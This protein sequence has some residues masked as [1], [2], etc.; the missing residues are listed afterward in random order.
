MASMREKRWGAAASVV[1][2]TWLVTGG[3]YGGPFSLSSTE[4][5]QGG[6]W[7]AGPGLPVGM[8]SHC[9][10]TVGQGVVVTGRQLVRTYCQLLAG[11]HQASPSTR[12]EQLCFVKLMS[13]NIYNS[14]Y[15]II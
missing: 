10:V 9:Q 5:L 2:D 14:Y 1:N 6:G 7:V 11:Q 4:M 15:N 3:Y 8:E 13:N 12:V